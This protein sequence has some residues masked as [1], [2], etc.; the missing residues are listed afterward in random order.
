MGVYYKV[1][2]VGTVIRFL[3]ELCEEG[4][5]REVRSDEAL[6]YGEDPVV[7]VLAETVFGYPESAYKLAI[8]KMTEVLERRRRIT[9]QVRQDLD[10]GFT[11]AS[12]Y[13]K[14]LRKLKF[15]EA[16]MAVVRRCGV[17]VTDRIDAQAT[18]LF[19]AEDPEV[20]KPVARSPEFRKS[21]HNPTGRIK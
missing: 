3:G 10:I 17:P 6:S 1:S 12:A 9:E 18:V 21:P 14:T 20:H 2:K 4:V 19:Y 15:L 7:G 11:D 8:A 16:Q 13:Q 5:V